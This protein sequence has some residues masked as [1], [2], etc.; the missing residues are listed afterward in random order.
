MRSIIILTAIAVIVTACETATTVENDPA[1]T[2]QSYYA[3]FNRLDNAVEAGATLRK[4]SP[5]GE[6]LSLVGG[7]ALTVNGQSMGYSNATS[8]SYFRRI[9]GIVDA[10]YGL[11]FDQGGNITTFAN[12]IFTT[13]V[14]T[15]G[16]PA[17][18]F[19][20]D[21]TT[22]LEVIWQGAPVGVNEV[23]AVEFKSPTGGTVTVNQD[24]VG[25]NNVLVQ[26]DI[27]R[28]IA[29]SSTKWRLIRTR[30]GL[31]LQQPTAAGGTMAV[32]WTTGFNPVSWR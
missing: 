25:A 27:I 13:D 2:W 20:I 30:S 11:R 9:T 12:T 31:S 1:T 24:E 6:V 22:D 3:E 16:Y 26:E 19:L 15:I 18:D 8:A 17:A 32:A 21:S 23:V 29:E 4:G 5:T 14:D 28:S 7:S 10:G